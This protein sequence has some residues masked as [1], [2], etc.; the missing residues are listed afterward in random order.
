VAVS[1][2]AI[3]PQVSPG[4]RRSPT[5]GWTHIATFGS[6]TGIDPA[7]PLQ[8]A[9]LGLSADEQAILAGCTIARLRSTAGSDASCTN[10]YAPGRP[11]VLGVGP[12][13]IGRDGFR[14]AVHAPLPAGEV[15]PWTLLDGSR[16]GDGPIPCVLDQATAQWAL[17]VGGV[18]D[19]FEIPG[20]DGERLALEIVGLLEPGILQGS[21]IVGERDFERMF[22]RRSGYLL[23]LV[24]APAGWRPAA[25]GGDPVTEA[26]AAA[27][28]DAA[29][30]V[31]T[32][33]SRFASLA[34]V[35]N[36]FLGGFQAL[37][38][39]GLLL[40]TAGLAA[41]QL[42]NVL[43]RRGQIGFLRAIGFSADRVR[44][45]IVIETLVMVGLGL[46]VGAAAGML[47]VMPSLAGGRAAVP[48]GWILATSS[49]ALFVAAAA[50]VAA[51][52]RAATISLRETLEMA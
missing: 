41:V 31:Q 42:Q 15:N 38:T 5:G 48:I 32:A 7:D 10:L 11:N 46:A 44:G 2:F 16:R 47:A 18:G 51:A 23:A 50:G 39:L 3:V 1:S 13:F 6:P 25:G 22:P 9:S 20:D 24:E 34:A 49:L 29:A 17:K 27:W 52:R 45:L 37:G 30:T 14:F 26:I 43:E 19:R 8:H 28:A 33:S 4:D 12:A 40:G 36:T 21:V 35:Q